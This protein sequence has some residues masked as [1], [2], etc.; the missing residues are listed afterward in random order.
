MAQLLLVDSG[1]S[2]IGASRPH[3]DTNSVGLLW[4]NDQPDAE[5]S[6]WKHTTQKRQ[7][8]VLFA[9][10]E[11]TLP[12]ASEGPQTHASDRATTGTGCNVYYVLP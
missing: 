3:S 4:T 9:G 10:F 8:S 7:T 5:N 12:A 6:T 2:I 1:L 11:P